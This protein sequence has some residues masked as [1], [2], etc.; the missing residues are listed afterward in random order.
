MPTRK[1]TPLERLGAFLETRRGRA[2]VGALLLAAGPALG[3][4]A[5]LAELAVEEA[6]DLECVPRVV[7]APVVPVP[8]PVVETAPPAEP[9]TPEVVAPVEPP[10]AA[11]PDN[12]A[13]ADHEADA[14]PVD[15]PVPS[16]AVE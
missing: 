3:L 15:A 8:V 1:P 4:P 11:E 16:A 9:T 7:A 14:P 13:G 10:P 6:Y 2:L 12:T 5:G